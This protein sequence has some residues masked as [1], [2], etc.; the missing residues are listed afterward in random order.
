MFDHDAVTLFPTPDFMLRRITAHEVM[1][2]RQA[3]VENLGGLGLS[4]GV[5]DPVEVG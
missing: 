3:A 1:G 5:D 4:Q 2:E